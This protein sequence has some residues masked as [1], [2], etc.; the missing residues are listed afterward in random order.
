MVFGPKFIQS[1][2]KIIVP[3]T[4]ILDAFN[5]NTGVMIGRTSDDGNYIYSSVGQYNYVNNVSNGA[6][7]INGTGH[8]ASEYR[9][10]CYEI[11]KVSDGSGFGDPRNCYLRNTKSTD[12]DDVLLYVRFVIAKSVGL[13]PDNS[14]CGIL[15]LELQNTSTTFKRTVVAHREPGGSIVNMYLNTDTAMTGAGGG[16]IACRAWLT[17]TQIRVTADWEAYGVTKDT[18]FMNLPSWFLNADLSQYTMALYIR[19]YNGTPYNF[20][21]NFYLSSADYNPS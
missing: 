14:N 10:S 4:H 16:N 11:S 7:R 6:Q 8:T 21:Q 2:K 9:T 13:D 17:D 3:K 12:R 19:Q 18:D 20:P 15:Y 5:Q 1:P